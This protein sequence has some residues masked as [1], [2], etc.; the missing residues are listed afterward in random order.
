ML[1]EGGP[2]YGV[3]TLEPVLL[4]GGLDA[5]CGVVRRWRGRSHGVAS[6]GSCGV[7]HLERELE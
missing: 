5:M 7:V 6:V 3:V 2:I 1:R 4:D